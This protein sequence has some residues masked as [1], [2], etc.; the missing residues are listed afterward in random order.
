MTSL[1]FYLL[2]S[3]AT[4]P[5]GNKHKTNDVIITSQFYHV[6]VRSSQLLGS[7]ME[8]VLISNSVTRLVT[9]HC[10]TRWCNSAIQ[11]RLAAWQKLRWCE[12]KLCK[13]CFTKYHYCTLVKI[14]SWPPDH[15]VLNH[16]IPS[17]VSS[18]S[19]TSTHGNNKFTWTLD[20]WV[21]TT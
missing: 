10:V 6:T 13:C 15:L 14:T 7:Q 11:Q 17:H 9:W 1:V 19:L 5:L 2:P 4:A 21:T 12:W 20:K 3:A 8:K 18:H 16:E